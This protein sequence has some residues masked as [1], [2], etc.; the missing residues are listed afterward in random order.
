MHRHTQE[1]KAVVTS[2][3]ST[4]RS[5]DQFDGLVTVLN[6]VRTGSA[7]TR[8]ELAQRSGLGRTIIADR[9]ERLISAGLVA[10]GALGASTGGRAPRQLSFLADAGQVLVAVLG[11]STIR[12]A[13][14]DLAGNVRDQRMILAD[15]TEGPEPILA[16]I[17]SLFDELLGRDSGELW[18]IGVGLPGP[19]EF[20]TGRPVAPPIM[21]G[22]DRYDVRGHF[23]AARNVPVW[24]DNDVNVMVLGELRRGRAVGGRDVVFVKVGS[25]IGAGL[26]SRGVLHRGA[27]GCA[28]DIGH[29][30][31]VND[32]TV[33]C[34]CGNVGCLEALAGGIAIARDATAAALNGSSERL[35]AVLTE[36]GALR[37]G[38]VIAAA[39]R[40]DQLSIDLLS[41]SAQ[42]VGDS[43]AAIVN[44]F[45]P[46]LIIIGGQVTVDN[47]RYLA[48]VRS[49]VLRRSLPLAT[50]S[51]YVTTS[52]LGELAGV[53][54]AVY[55]VVDELLSREGLAS[56][57]HAHPRVLVAEQLTTV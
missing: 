12:V 21:P 19:V 35:R 41:Y 48:T 53:I 47:D 14:A 1:R 6:L 46:A 2:E 29:V 18:G 9:V 15:V 54:G 10:E 17:D 50:R 45:N 40:G 25:G 33:M 7:G 16:K 13:L 49:T 30:M 22:W 11:A 44:F 8:P 36:N 23:A 39:K 4:V 37:P 34:R 56:W 38:D 26:V 43:L 27:Q 57:M 51:L 55:M 20:A 24:V 3:S 28:G 52:P 5:P 31:A 32:S 42:L